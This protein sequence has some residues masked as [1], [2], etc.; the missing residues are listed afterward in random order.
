[1]GS[2]ITMETFRRSASTGACACAPATDGSVSI[3]SVPLDLG[4]VVAFCDLWSAPS[5][6]IANAVSTSVEQPA[7]GNG[8]QT[9]Q[10]ESKETRLLEAASSSPYPEYSPE[11]PTPTAP[12]KRST[13]ADQCARG[14]RSLSIAN[15]GQLDLLGFLALP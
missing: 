2:A 11:D 4:A 14:K 8:G 10:C 9:Q 6:M 13:H 12:S 3:A 5:M 15:A 1:M 7:S